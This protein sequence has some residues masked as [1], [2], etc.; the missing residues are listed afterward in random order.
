[1]RRADPHRAGQRPRPV[2]RR[3]RVGG[4]GDGHLDAPHIASTSRASPWPRCWCSPRCW[5]PTRSCSRHPCPSCGGRPG[6]RPVVGQRHRRRPQ[7]ADER[8]LVGDVLPRRADPDHRAGPE[9]P[10]RGDHRRDGRA[11]GAQAHRRCRIDKRRRATG[12]RAGTDRRGQLG[13]RD[14]GRPRVRLAF[15]DRAE[16]PII[17]TTTSILES[18]T[19]AV[20]LDERLAE[21]RRIELDRNDRLVYAR[22]RPRCSRWRTSRSASRRRRRQRRRPRE[23]HRAAGRDAGAGRRVRLRQVDHLARPSWVCSTRV[24]RSAARSCSTAGTCWS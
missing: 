11:E 6:S 22:T 24:R 14:R 5:S 20:P 21:L 1:M 18:T 10:L 4:P 9:H 16:V 2:R 17:T 12:R 13:R 3:L 23:L 8:R 7:P 15:A 19:T